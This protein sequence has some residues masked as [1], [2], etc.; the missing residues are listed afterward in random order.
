MKLNSKLKKK[1]AK[2][3]M[4]K[5]EKTIHHKKNAQKNKMLGAICEGEKC[6]LKLFT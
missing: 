5:E 1:K 4:K 2:R 6:S 3:W